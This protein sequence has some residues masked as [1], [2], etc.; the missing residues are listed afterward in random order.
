[1]TKEERLN[2]IYTVVM[3]ATHGSDKELEKAFTDIFER[4]TKAEVGII[5]VAL[6]TAGML[7]ERFTEVE[8]MGVMLE[9]LAPH[10]KPAEPK[11]WLN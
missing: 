2:A 4:A 1:M 7:E 6:V 9:K 5:M 8:R 11:G 3:Q 10:D